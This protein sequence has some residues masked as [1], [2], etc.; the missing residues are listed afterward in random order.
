[1]NETAAAAPGGSNATI[2]LV[3]AIIVLLL[4]RRAVLMVRGAPVRPAALFGFAA[5]YAV[6]FALSVVVDS[7]GAPIYFLL[8]DLIIVAVAAVLGARHIL[9]VL[10]LER[11]SD[12]R[13]YY[14]LPPWIPI[15]YIGLFLL[16]LVLSY[17]IL[18]PSSFTFVR[19]ASVSLSPLDL[20]ALQTVDALFAASTGILIARS[21][22][23]YLAYRKATAALGSPPTPS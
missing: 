16:R 20:A 21:V 1:M 18:G 9:V 8:A 4:V 23:V 3:L 10:R 14:Q 12:G 19:S 13:W 5:F 6:L 17:E 2:L 7:A 22:G 15:V 11:R